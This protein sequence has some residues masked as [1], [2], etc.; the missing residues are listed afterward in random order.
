MLQI[1]SFWVEASM[2]T[3]RGMTLQGFVDEKKKFLLNYYFSPMLKP[4]KG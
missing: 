2:E 3:L 1:S 4:L